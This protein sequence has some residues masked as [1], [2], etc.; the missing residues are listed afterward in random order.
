MSDLSSNL[1]SPRL[2]QMRR[3][4]MLRGSR[5][6]PWFRPFNSYQERSSMSSVSALLAPENGVVPFTD[7]SGQVEQLLRWS[8]KSDEFGIAEICGRRGTGKTRLALELALQLAKREWLCGIV[9]DTPDP[10]GL[11]TIL[12]RTTNRLFILEL[13]EVPRSDEVFEQFSD[14]LLAHQQQGRTRF[15]CTWTGDAGYRSDVSRFEAA[16][17]GR[18]STGVLRVRLT[19][20]GFSGEKQAEFT[21]LCLT[22]FS[23]ALG[24]EVSPAPT[25]SESYS[26]SPL[27]IQ[28]TALRELLGRHGRDET[29]SRET[30]VYDALLRQDVKGGTPA[31][32][33]DRARRLVSRWQYLMTAAIVVTQASKE[34]TPE[35]LGWLPPFRHLDQGS[36]EEI[37]TWL[38]RV[39]GSDD[40]SGF[41]LSEL[42][43]KIA[44]SVVRDALVRDAGVFQEFLRSIDSRMLEQ[45]LTYAT[46]LSDDVVAHALLGH[47]LSRE[48]NRWA[49]AAVRVACR[50]DGV[51]RSALANALRSVPVTPEEAALLIEEI[52]HPSIGMAETAM[53]L[54]RRSLEE[55]E[56][57][58]RRARLLWQLSAWLDECGQF[59][60]AVDRSL[61]AVSIARSVTQTF[62]ECLPELALALL[63]CSRSQAVVRMYAEAR[64]NAEEAVAIR[65]ESTPQEGVNGRLSLA[66]AMTNLSDRLSD[67]GEWQESLNTAIEAVALLRSPDLAGKGRAR[68]ELAL[69]LDALGRRQSGCG[70]TEAAL[71]VTSEAVDLWRQAC[72]EHADRYLP[73]L[74]ISLSGLSSRLVEQGRTAE[75]LN[76]CSEAERISE[77]LA[78]IDSQAFSGLWSSC[79]NNLS[80]RFSGTSRP[81][82]ALAAIRQAVSIYR[83]LA[84]GEHAVHR[85]Y[86]AS[87]L[88]NLGACLADA[89]DAVGA[90][91]A[92]EEAAEI[93]S[94]ARV[95]S[96]GSWSREYCQSLLGLAMQLSATGRRDRSLDLLHR[97]KDA[98]IE[99]TGV[100]P[101]FG[102]LLHA[103]TLEA[104]AD[105]MQE[106]GH[107]GEAQE[108]REE[109]VRRYSELGSEDREALLRRFAAALNLVAPKLA[110]SGDE[111]TALEAAKSSVDLY[112][113]MRG[114][115]GKGYSTDLAGALLKYGDVLWSAGRSTESVV[116][117]AE[118]VRILRDSRS[119]DDMAYRR[120]LVTALSLLARRSL[121]LGQ[122]DEALA[123]LSE[124]VKNERLLVVQRPDAFAKGL[125]G[126]LVALEPVLRDMGRTDDA[127][128]IMKQAEKLQGG[129]AFDKLSS[130]EWCTAGP[131]Q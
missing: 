63:Q 115:G 78:N 119:Q 32:R 11:L 52:P 58:H 70:L 87:S 89:G 68:Q 33:S 129:M 4:L 117:T 102:V 98:A 109:V 116:V 9:E 12:E 88:C 38:H 64:Q 100:D 97:A 10:E 126:S 55:S 54:C 2:R 30:W 49:H 128:A 76:A 69:A 41:I 124:V 34:D 93:Y 5:I 72:A 35:V 66:S 15:V 84:R 50:E 103:R 21:K 3:Q 26:D 25:S 81:V 59:S 28:L 101:K 92:L 80:N 121:E 114:D 22:A 67:C 44:E 106:E 130:P 57:G 65:R 24:K 77:R 75:A 13:D 120:T 107:E 61:E 113:M 96:P 27:E 14:F 125:H 17:I 82:D 90:I 19:P 79:L 48:S 45:C 31:V 62:P 127:L 86:L 29:L 104:L 112:R 42:P 7:S 18:S 111:G 20:R 23:N 56:P 71:A 85:P 131:G 53:L 95:A 60:E 8:L 91:D 118:C 16:T 73:H 74:A 108:L 83:K 51:L 47:L 46:R 39:Y 40:N 110:A 6:S 1:A 37:A 43:Q 94:T 99:A 122:L 105:E 36:R 123:A